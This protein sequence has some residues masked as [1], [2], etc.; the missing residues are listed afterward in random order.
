MIKVKIN[1][2]SF[3]M[4]E[5]A[6]LILDAYLDK[7]NI[8]LEKN[9][10]SQQEFDETQKNI[11]NALILL[12]D[13][14]SNIEKEDIENIIEKSKIK[15]IIKEWNQKRWFFRILWQIIKNFFK[16]IFNIIINVLKI[17]LSFIIILLK[18]IILLIKIVFLII[19]FSIILVFIF[20]VP[21]VFFPWVIDNQII[22]S[23]V[24]DIFKYGLIITE[25]SF[26]LLFTYFLL[27]IVNSKFSK[28]WILAATIITFIIWINWMVYGW[29]HMYYNYG[30]TFDKIEKYTFEI[31]NSKEISFEWLKKLNLAFPTF[32]S[33]KN[34]EDCNII[35]TTDY[36]IINSTW[37]KLE[38]E[39]ITT[40]ND[41]NK[42]EADKY[43]EKLN[44]L[45]FVLQWNNIILETEKE[46]LFKEIVP[47]KFIRRDIV[48][49]KPKDVI[50]ND[51][52]K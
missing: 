36:E 52:Y 37:S 51:F 11:E 39:I 1:K 12:L 14:Q 24:P 48:V 2:M 19:I 18:L 28:N 29:Y 7:I 6:S 22:L 16:I 41:K 10:I 35:Y 25:V 31:K 23:F 46:K 45:N 15:K 34:C 8:Y 5:D 13:K 26:G 30:Q 47:Y 43:F 17:I 38:I 4:S 33:D 9:K 44:N 20:L 50:I 42:S 32:W 3:E 49:K 27:S 40:I 21:L